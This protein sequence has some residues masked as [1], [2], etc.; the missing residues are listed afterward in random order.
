MTTPSKKTHSYHYHGHVHG[1]SAH[2][3]RPFVETI[4][5]Q[6]AASLPIIGG[7]GRARAENF[8]FKEIVS[9]Q[10]AYSHVS[11]SFSEDD[12]SHNT[13]VTAVVE[14]LNVLDVLT[15]ERIVLR[16]ASHHLPKEEEARIIPLGCRFEKLQ[17]AGCEV[18]VEVDTDTFGE[19]DTYA[20][21]KTR[22]EKDKKF[23]EMAEERF[24][25]G[26]LKKDVP[27][28]IRTRYNWVKQKG[29]PEAP[30]AFV[31]SLVKDIDTTKCSSVKRYGHV[32]VVP[33]FGRVFLGEIIFKHSERIVTMLRLELGSS[34]S[35]AIT[36]S[37]G[38]G[39]GSP[40][41]PIG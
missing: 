2:F 25:W 23:R 27:E 4:D 29:L 20:T 36:A 18:D 28:F 17:I 11:G 9:F 31:C 14:K 39:N 33:E 40:Y 22:F 8:K 15:A 1:L 5:V 19:L 13:L 32:L 30:G 10:S 12:E 16:L 35:G 24:L 26:D 34:I 37:G 38:S 41:P 7:H 6:A 3:D 21:F